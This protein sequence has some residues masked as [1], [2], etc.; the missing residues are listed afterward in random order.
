VLLLKFTR[1]KICALAR[2]G[3]VCCCSERHVHAYTR[4]FAA[5]AAVA[6]AA[7]A[8]ATGCCHC[9]CHCYCCCRA[10]GPSIRI[11]SH[12]LQPPLR[13]PTGS[14]CWPRIALH[15]QAG[16]TTSSMWGGASDVQ[17]NSAH[18]MPACPLV[19]VESMPR[20]HT[21][22]LSLSLSSIRV[23]MCAQQK[24]TV[25]GLSHVNRSR[26]PT[27]RPRGCGLGSCGRARPSVTRSLSAAW[28]P[29]A[30]S[31]HHHHFYH[32]SPFQ[33]PI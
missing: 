19:F 20:K 2:G 4:V 28:A 29:T 16:T 23:C 18:P 13:Q 14:H 3:V 9:C 7:A 31:E 24:H 12:E 22:I 17:V 1:V 6:A 26:C 15:R 27:E 33:P 32:Q 30:S 8:A 21:H 25:Y 11:P 10:G 5:A